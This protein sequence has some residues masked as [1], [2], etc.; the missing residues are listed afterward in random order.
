MKQAAAQSY[1][2]PAHTNA[3]STQA[4]S[5]RLHS[6]AQLSNR[7]GQ[8]SSLQEAARALARRQTADGGPPNQRRLFRLRSYR[9]TDVVGIGRYPV[10]S[11]GKGERKATMID[12]KAR[13]GSV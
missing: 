8:C 13:P 3:R 9:D 4:P 7:A 12:K 1:L 11:T 2:A 6:T 10:C 5:C